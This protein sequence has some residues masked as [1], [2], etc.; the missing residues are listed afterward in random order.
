MPET[1]HQATFHPGVQ[2]WFDENYAYPTECQRQAWPAIQNEQNVLVAAPTGSGKTLAAFL[3]AIDEL[4][5]IGLQQQSLPEQVYIV[6][7]SPLK[8]LS[9]DIERNLRGPLAGIREYLVSGGYADVE[10][11]VGVRTGDTSYSERQKMA[12]KPPHILVTTP[13]SLYLLLT[14]ASGRRMLQSV[15]RLIVDEIHA[16]ADNKRGSHL[17]LSIA[18][19]EWLLG[20]APKKTGL[21]ATQKPLSL[22]ASFLSGKQSS[23]CFIVDAGHI[24]QWDLAI[25]LPSAPLQA[26]LSTEA[27]L[28]LYQKLA[29]L[30]REHR[31]TLIFVNTR[32]HAER[33]TR[34]LAEMVGEQNIAA[35]HGSLSKD[36]RHDTEQRLK[37][38]Q[39]K[40]IVATASLE[41]GIDIG[42]VDLVCQ[43]CSP[44]SIAVFLQR[45]G[46]SGHAVGQVPKG[47]LFPTTRDELVESA[48]LLKA[49]AAGDLEAL[50]LAPFSADV[51]AQQIVAESSVREC[52][53][54]ELHTQF[55]SALPYAQLTRET[56]SEIVQMLTDGFT[57]RR[58]R[59]GA[60]LHLD[61]VNKIVRGRRGAKM[62]ATTNAGAIPDMF[63]F[64]VILEPEDIRIGTVN[65]EFAF[66][67]LIGDVFQLGN[68]SYRIIRVDKGSVR[69]AD[70]QGVLPNIPFW[71][72]EGRGRSAELSAA[73]SQLRE[74]VGAE[75]QKTELKAVMEKFADIYLVDAQAAEQIVNYLALAQKSLGTIPSSKAIV[76][77]RFFD[78][79]GDAHLVVHSVFGSRLNRAWGL[80]LR[81][82][83]CVRFNFELQAAAL[84]DCFILSLGPTHSFA[85]DEV[86]KYVTS[87]LLEEVLRQA[88]L[89]AP[90]FATRWRWVANIALAVL[91][92]RGGKKVPP[93]FQRNDAEDLMSLIFPAQLAC[94]EN[95]TGPIE[96]P[97]HP[98]IDQTLYDCLHELMDTNGLRQL[99]QRI[100]H[101]EI[102]IVCKDTPEP[103]VLAQ[104]VLTARPYAFLDDVP[105]EERRTRVVQSPR[106]AQPADMQAGSELDS[107]LIRQLR[108]KNWPQPRD[109]EELHDALVHMGFMLP[110][111]WSISSAE[112]PDLSRQLAQQR[113]FVELQEAKRVTSLSTANASYWVCAERLAQ[114]QAIHPHASLDPVIEPASLSEHC[115]DDFD[116]SLIA[117]IRS[118][119]EFV[120]LCQAD[121]IAGS[122]DLPL[123]KIES[124]LLALEAEGNLM[125][126]MFDP[127]VESQQWCDRRFLARVH[128]NSILKRRAQIK[129]V[130]GAQFV[131]YLM[132][133]MRVNPHDTGEGIEALD[134]VIGQFEG[135]EAPA[136]AWE[137]ELLPTRISGYMPEMLDY[138]SASG[139]IVWCRL[140]KPET[141]ATSAASHKR[142]RKFR[143]SIKTVPLTFI[144]RR[145]LPMW[146][147]IAAP[148]T[149][150]SLKLTAAAQ[151]IVESLNELGPLFFDEIIE[152]VNQLP[153]HVE[154]ALVELFALGVVT[155]DHFGGIRALLT[156]VRYRRRRT[157]AGRLFNHGVQVSGR[158][159]L[160]LQ[161]SK[162]SQ[163]PSATVTPAQYAVQA[164]LNRYGVVF[165]DLML[166][167]GR[168]LPPWGEL[169]RELRRLEDRGEV[170]GGRFVESVAGEQFAV[171]EAL[172][173]LRDV[174]S[175]KAP[176]STVLI[177]PSDPV[178][179]SG[180]IDSNRKVAAHSKGYLAYRNGHLVNVMVGKSRRSQLLPLT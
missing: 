162:M 146:L 172:G 122:L 174:A 110:D 136:S 165:R 67:S 83:F 97:S 27:W 16:L 158:W 8:A 35:H 103:S 144:S 168:Y 31:T 147:E 13:E 100:E 163:A 74:F 64:E 152:Q 37:A 69:V 151:Q 47:R 17:S 18:R 178:N 23:D 48:A 105:A 43:L 39:L 56:L 169:L 175:R 73:V 63:D 128:K 76:F 80:A 50:Q 81:K 49:V 120:G 41:L 166:N 140:S 45:I 93:P 62:T 1:W 154:S 96:I 59:R 141:A 84:D 180:V 52:S 109:A 72:G 114:M 42:D 143:G 102:E 95:I 25:S 88:V 138:L 150:E 104:E 70:A 87:Q 92:F 98:L 137:A 7:V 153:S 75:L 10:L 135:Y 111:E 14:S 90:M 3:A 133:W 32:R 12:R 58:G 4:I 159:S 99:L 11:R 129:P 68:A 55:S 106:Y 86:Q 24:R 77:E 30:I 54:D 15:K 115:P 161:R 82:K 127:D 108:L 61:A 155:C 36:H 149:D 132:A 19:L 171:P 157:R 53:I 173:L 101:K 71:F 38:G 28:E 118:R 40:A 112:A 160:L 9:Y 148:N 164:L 125:R 51:L 131:E 121:Q 29:E 20:Y 85:L 44:H 139:R 66:E 170:R 130:A 124:A 126:G 57:L 22:I 117:I 179:L 123:G 119:M 156:P 142:E 34:Y 2:R 79:T 177:H 6:Y 46:R 176:S 33:A 26:V 89:G 167:E 65:E 134:Q 116:S 91:R 5:Q 107:D 78:E 113:W 94:Q 21:S 60:Y 145:A